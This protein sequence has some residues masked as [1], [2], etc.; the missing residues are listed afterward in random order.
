MHSILSQLWF[1][2]RL[3]AFH[4]PSLFLYQSWPKQL[5]HR[6][7]SRHV[8]VN[9]RRSRCRY[10]SSCGRPNLYIYY[11]TIKHYMSASCFSV[12][13]QGRAAATRLVPTACHCV[14]AAEG[15]FFYDH[16]FRNWLEQS[17]HKPFL[18]S[19][20][21]SIKIITQGTHISQTFLRI[22]VIFFINLSSVC[23]LFSQ[24]N[25]CTHIF[26]LLFIENPSIRN[27]YL[28]FLTPKKRVLKF[29]M[30]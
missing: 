23:Q 30:G 16:W 8:R 25:T 19:I 20:L 21:T 26:F 17:R 22:K 28:H 14:P 12:I 29:P 24:T 27:E 9:I 10:E 11:S 18:E 1:K 15:N 3:V 2:K 6:W 4:A 13:I 7:V 5:V